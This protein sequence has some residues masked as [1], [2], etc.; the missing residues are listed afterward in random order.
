MSSASNVKVL[1][2]MIRQERKDLAIADYY[3]EESRTTQFEVNA[4][5]KTRSVTSVQKITWIIEEKIVEAFKDEGGSMWQ[6]MKKKKW[7]LP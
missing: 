6:C 5:G 2:L 3:E 4:E 1:A 7:Y